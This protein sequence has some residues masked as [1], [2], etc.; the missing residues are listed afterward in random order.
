MNDT[1]NRW[2]KNCSINCSDKKQKCF[3]IYNTNIKNNAI[4]LAR[5]ISKIIENKQIFKYDKCVTNYE[6]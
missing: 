5:K 3:Y 4:R 1:V 2:K 6:N